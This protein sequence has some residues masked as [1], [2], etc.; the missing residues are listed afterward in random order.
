MDPALVLGLRPDIV[1][2]EMVERSLNAPA[3]FPLKVPAR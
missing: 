2:E 3:A 1:I